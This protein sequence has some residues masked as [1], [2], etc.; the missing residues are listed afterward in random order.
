[1][2]A[3]EQ[4]GLFQ[5]RQHRARFEDSYRIVRGDYDYSTIVK[6]SSFLSQLDFENAQS[7]IPETLEHY[8]FI[9]PIIN[10]LLG[11]YIKKPDPLTVHAED[12]NSV[13]DF[14]ITLRDKLRENVN[15]S[16][17]RMMKIAAMKRGMDPDKKNFQ[18]EEERQAYLQELEKIR[19][20]VTPRDIVN[21]MRTEWKPIYIEW[22]EKTLEENQMRYDL[23]DL[24]RDMFRDYLITG[25]AFKHHR[26][27]HNRYQPELWSPIN[28]FTS[29]T[30]RQKYPELGDY[31]GHIEYMS[32]V[33]VVNLF[34]EK[35]TARQQ[36]K[37]LKS[38]SYTPGN[39]PDGG[40][41]SMME[42]AQQSGHQPTLVSH[43]HQYQFDMIDQFQNLTGQYH[44]WNGWFGEHG[45]NIGDF[46]VE[47]NQDWRTD[48]VRVTEMYWKSM[49]RFGYLVA[50]N[51]ETGETLEGLYSDE[52]ASELLKDW[53]VKQLSS[54]TME[55]AL[56]NPKDN[57]ITWFFLPKVRYG[58]KISEE[59]TDLDED[60]YLGGD[61]L[62]YQLNGETNEFH[63]KLPVTGI[64]E[65][66]SLVSRVEV[67]QS[68]YSMVLNMARDYMSREL[69]V[70]FLF[71][72]AYLPQYLKDL[73]EEESIDAM[74]DL[75]RQTG[76]MDVDST[77]ARGTSFNQ[78]QLVNMD[79][80]RPMMD[81]MAIAQQIKMR[82]YEKLGLNPQ[83][84][85]QAVEAT[86]ARGVQVSQ[87]AS[88]AQTEVWFDKFSQVQ[89]RDAE[90]QINISQ[91][92]AYTGK[93]V[94]VQYTDN[95]THYH[96][97]KMND[98]D[99][100]MRRFKIFVQNTSKRRA[101]LELIKQTFFSDNTI[102]K[103]LQDMAEV[104]GA[105]SVS[106][107]LRVSRA[108]RAQAEL[109]ELQRRQHE[110]EMQLQKIQA[111]QLAEEKKMQ[112]EKELEMIKG[113][114]ALRK[115]SI[116]ALG[117]SE[118]KDIDANQS[119]DVVDELKAGLES[120]KAK[121]ADF[122]KREQLRLERTKADRDFMIKQ[123]K[124]TNDRRAVEVKAQAS[125]DAV[126]IARE[127]KNRFD[128]K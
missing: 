49:E 104:I 25:R 53:E 19:Q 122:L 119:P 28:T 20:E 1:M 88:Y 97:M 11:E 60:L 10:V 95:N 118:D 82:A 71:D 8:A 33:E 34:A 58:I 48:M 75:I 27:A 36:R 23:E 5:L 18:S 45:T 64:V 47:T 93:D 110:K 6:N 52:V 103:D 77:K 115:Q 91:W 46:I 43:E 32:N 120:F 78:F 106:K 87:D 127:N 65:D 105:D 62:E 68:E 24:G 66:T 85:A 26:I 7:E 92:L 16:V 81:K 13:N 67:E 74:N 22:A 116:L 2:D 73:P 57:T 39:K 86:T 44:G 121:S 40:D 70:F 124:M 100:P 72:R 90:V 35:L 54:E 83:R 128:E 109:R 69:G 94:T 108:R 59:N 61:L 55:E 112:H 41:L 96:F 63:A 51:P 42:V 37:I 113:E 17:T 9:E 80:S 76:I 107:V 125:K 3:L 21:T 84:M 12:E 117:F 99:L 38:E 102:E 50:V 15:E 114:I 56:K 89:K 4:I 123:Q 111:D 14:L 30:E 98:P 31:V 29:I 101:E 79:L 126:T